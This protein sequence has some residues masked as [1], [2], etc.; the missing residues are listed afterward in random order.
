[1]NTETKEKK[2]NPD[3]KS[4]NPE[5]ALLET[6]ML[7]KS[8]NVVGIV[9]IDR[10]K[11]MPAILRIYKN[12]CKEIQLP[13]YEKTGQDVLNDIANANFDIASILDKASADTLLDERANKLLQEKTETL[14]MLCDFCF[15]YFMYLYTTE[16]P[17]S[18]MPSTVT[19]FKLIAR[20]LNA[21]K[22][23]C[24]IFV[25]LIPDPFVRDLYRTIPPFLMRTDMKKQEIIAKISSYNEIFKNLIRKLL[26]LKPFAD[27]DAIKDFL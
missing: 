17:T 4:V 10:D 22:E 12:L 26:I 1:M 16:L 9:G 11:L 18:I 5:I 13:N 8:D 25:K 6:K 21:D 15:I 24:D 20:H 27:K 14:P 3:E 2:I 19:R 23:T 7:D